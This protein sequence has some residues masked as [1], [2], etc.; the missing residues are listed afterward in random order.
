MRTVRILTITIT[1]ALL[2]VGAPQ[3]RAQSQD[4]LALMQTFL[5]IMTDYFDIIEST[6]D[7]AADP[8]KAAIMYCKTCST[9]AVTRRS[10]MRPIS[11]SATR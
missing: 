2:L 7:I 3:A 6:R 10:A 9:R 1:A 11:C 8:E 5:S 4:D